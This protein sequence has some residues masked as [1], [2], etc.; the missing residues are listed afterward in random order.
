MK[1]WKTCPECR[2]EN[3]EQDQDDGRIYHCQNCG[4]TFIKCEDCEERGKCTIGAP[5]T[6]SMRNTSFGPRAKCLSKL[7]EI[8]SKKIENGKG[9]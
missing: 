7:C 8:V 1:T 5:K 9:E 3:T 4:L 6:K 2:S